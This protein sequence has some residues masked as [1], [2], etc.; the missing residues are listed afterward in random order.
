MFN[1]NTTSATSSQ[2]RRAD[3]PIY[4]PSRHRQHHNVHPLII[5]QPSKPDYDRK[6]REMKG[7]IVANKLV[8]NVRLPAALEED[9]S[10]IFTWYTNE[11]NDHQ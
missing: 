5:R 10:R 3:V 6:G 1:T 2:T 11:L 4:C 7:D 9:A 8:Y